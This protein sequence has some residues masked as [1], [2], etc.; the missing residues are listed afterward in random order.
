MDYELF[1]S[2]INN[3]K[4]GSRKHFDAFY[5]LT[6]K[7]VYYAIL[8]IV[9]IKEDSE[10]IMQDVYISFIKSL[11]NIKEDSNS[12]YYLLQ[13]AKNKAI[14]FYNKSKR[15]TSCDD[16]S[17]A[18]GEVTSDVY[19]DIEFVKNKMS[20]DEWELVELCV[21]YGYKQVEVA[22][23]KNIPIAT[24]S[25]QYNKALEKARAIYNK[26]VLNENI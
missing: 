12:Y 17:Y 14:N 9:R 2:Y 11:P 21:L 26:E 19:T 15:V 24:L 5:D 1:N 7:S 6:S 10:D 20:K 23:I 13:I 18:E 22:K 4:K 25:Y 16:L 8:N 3:L